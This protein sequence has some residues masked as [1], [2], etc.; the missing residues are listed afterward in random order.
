MKI[1]L[2]TQNVDKILELTSLLLPYGLEILSLADYIVKEPVENG[3]NFVDNAIIKADYTY[4]LLPY[5]VLSDD[6]GLVIPELQNNPGV[7]SAR[8]AKEQG[9]YMEACTKIIEQLE[10]KQNKI[11]YFKTILC[12]YT[13]Y[14]SYKLFEGIVK[15][16]ISDKILG[17]KGFGY[18]SIF[19]PEG[20]KQTFA[21][22]SFEDKNK[23]SHRKN[24]MH[25]FIQ[26]LVQYKLEYNN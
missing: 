5:P 21:E 7:K 11:A 14:N 10:D 9:G 4:N 3:V 13:G 18:D 25:K 1:V 12:F 22:L 17:I 15:G 2:A 20:Y 8:W 16:K 6:S 19:I 26:Y 24:A 23:V